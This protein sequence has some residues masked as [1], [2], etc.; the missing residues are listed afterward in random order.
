MP[1]RWM[2][3]G[4]PLT[5]S[6]ADETCGVCGSTNSMSWVEE[7]EDVPFTVDSIT[8]PASGW[9]EEVAHSQQ[10]LTASLNFEQSTCRCGCGQP[11]A[12]DF[13]NAGHS[14]RYGA[15]LRAQAASGTQAATDE[16]LERGWALTNKLKQEMNFGV[17][18]EFWGMDGDSAAIH[19]QEAGM[20][21]R[22]DS[23]HHE[24]RDYWRITTDVSVSHEG[25]ELVSPI[26]FMHD[27]MGLKD[28]KLAISTLA[29]NGGKIDRSC[30]LHVHHDARRRSAAEIAATHGLYALF[31]PTIN[32]L[33]SPSRRGDAEFCHG[34]RVTEETP[35]NGWNY[36]EINAKGMKEYLLD[37]EDLPEMRTRYSNQRGKSL[38]SKL[39]GLGR[40]YTVNLNAYAI[41]RTIEFR[42][43]QGTL[44]AN[45]VINWVQFTSLFMNAYNNGLDWESLVNTYGSPKAINDELGV[46]GMLGF[47]GADERMVDF[48]TTRAAELA[49]STDEDDMSSQD[50]SDEYDEPTDIY[51]DE[52]QC[53]H[54]PC[55]DGQ[56]YCTTSEEDNE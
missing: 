43:H 46:T 55:D 37:G 42:Q 32:M 24:E 23:Y 18:A 11:V 33:V 28:T 49:N 22:A 50:S 6:C 21:A 10:N 47:L 35:Y 30:G 20:R 14:R 31:Q 1:G 34:L 13:V 54:Y 51:C 27:D 25:N 41:H 39:G 9:A 40:Y 52:C 56:C 16:L 3:N 17:E 12:R 45:K 2:F 5:P 19:L 53:E 44:N 29:K 26:L 8:S 36:P 7:G 15:M 4:Q 48:Y 38:R